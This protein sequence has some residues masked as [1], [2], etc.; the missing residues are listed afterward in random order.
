MLE[1]GGG[2]GQNAMVLA[3]MFP[4]STWITIDI[5]EAEILKGRQEVNKC[6]LDNLS[7]KVMDVCKLPPDWS[8][9]FDLVFACDVYHDIGRAEDPFTR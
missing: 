6:H 4:N 2:C 5:E 3:E 1:V 7:L 8:N 9:K